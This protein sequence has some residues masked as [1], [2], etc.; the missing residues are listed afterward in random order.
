MT[1]IYHA[2]LS[3][4]HNFNRVQTKRNDGFDCFEIES[5]FLRVCALKIKGFHTMNQ[6]LLENKSTS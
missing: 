1:Q 6:V 3:Q 4:P 5:F 2:Q